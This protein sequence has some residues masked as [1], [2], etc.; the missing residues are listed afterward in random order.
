MTNQAKIVPLSVHSP[1]LYT[2]PQYALPIHLHTS[3]LPVYT[4]SALVPC[5]QRFEP[6]TITCKGSCSIHYE[7]ASLTES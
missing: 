2:P 5:Q 7:T 4:G 3:P 1:T 6:T